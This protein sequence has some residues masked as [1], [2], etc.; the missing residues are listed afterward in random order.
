MRWDGGDV[1][2]WREWDVGGLGGG[3]GDL[4]VRVEEAVGVV[5]G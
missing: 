1:I 5:N 4:G 3:G 2:V